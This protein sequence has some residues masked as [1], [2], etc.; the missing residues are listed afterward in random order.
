MFNLTQPYKLTALPWVF[1]AQT[2]QFMLIQVILMRVSITMITMTM[3][4]SMNA[5]MT[6]LTGITTVMLV[7]GRGEDLAY[8][9][10]CFV[11]VTMLP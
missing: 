8:I 7:E 11:I 1:N 10:L 6:R 4:I 3:E 5:M 9:I 2:F